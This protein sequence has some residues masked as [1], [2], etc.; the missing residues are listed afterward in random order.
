MNVSDFTELSKLGSG[1]YGEV[2]RV[3]RKSDNCEYA[4]KKVIYA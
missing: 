2:L 3:L 4:M 1:S